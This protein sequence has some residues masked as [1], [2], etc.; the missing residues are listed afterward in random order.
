VPLIH[1]LTASFGAAMDRLGPFEPHPGVAVAVSGGADSLALVVLADGW[2]RE[3]GGTVVGLIVDHGLRAESAEEAR[4]TVERLAGIGVPSQVL[5]LTGLAHGSALAERA[6]VW[7]YAA[8]TDA[9]AR[10]GVLHL[11]LGHHAADQAETLAMRVLRDSGTH[12][13]AGMAALRETAGVRLLR[14]LLSFP[15]DALRALLTARGLAWVDDPSNRDLHTLRSRLRHGLGVA[16]EPALGTA[17]AAAGW[18]RRR[19]EE[20]IA[21]ELAE[22]AA[23]WPEG[24]ALV[25]PGRIGVAA[26]RSLIGMIG[27]SAYPPGA[28]QIGE[29]AAEL[30]PATVA[31]VR[32]L[33]AGRLGNGLL[34]VREDAAIG[35]PVRA[36]DGAIWDRRFRLVTKGDVPGGALI[37]ALGRDAVRFRRSSSLPSVVLRTLPGIRIGEKLAYV[38][39]LR[40]TWRENDTRASMVFSPSRQ[41][42]GAAFVPAE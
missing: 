3:R 9:C 37:G 12:G 4:V 28:A 8:L 10:A 14:P 35:G 23:I 40:Y 32:I 21:A 16:P 1:D 38:P 27:G 22:R 29:L 17:L 7:R 36:F 20:A 34:M 41:A 30:K 6:R 31:G 26:L 11:L 25:S 42:A 39:H 24:F 18:L 19:E 13:L 33:P 15:P 2:V 5:C